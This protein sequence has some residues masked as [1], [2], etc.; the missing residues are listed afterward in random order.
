[1]SHEDLAELLKKPQLSRSGELS[2]MLAA[3]RVVAMLVWILLLFNSVKAAAKL[4]LRALI[5][6]AA[7]VCTTASVATTPSFN[8]I[9]QSHA[10]FLEEAGHARD[11]EIAGF[12]S[13]FW[14]AC[15][16]MFIGSVNQLG[17][18][19]FGQNNENPF[20]M[21]L[22]LSILPGWAAASLEMNELNQTS[23]FKNPA[24]LGLCAL[25][26]DSPQLQAVA[27][28]FDDALSAKYDTVNK[29]IWGIDNDL[30]FVNTEDATSTKDIGGSSYFLETAA[31]VMKDAVHRMEHMVGD[32][33]TIISPKS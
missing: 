16:R 4:G 29:A 20:A 12:F 25:A 14:N 28:S 26:N 7:V 21:Q 13:H 24:L 32:S 31:A 17:P 11:V 5:G 3:P 23:R 1:M 8:I 18:A 27:G 6:K 33:H 2:Y 10:T 22:T 15:L 9:H 30:M 19:A